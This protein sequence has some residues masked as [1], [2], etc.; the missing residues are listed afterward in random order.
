MRAHRH[1]SAASTGIIPNG[2]AA[3]ALEA[4]QTALSGARGMRTG[5]LRRVPSA[6]R[7]AFSARGR[8]LG[9]LRSSTGSGWSAAHD[10]GLAKQVIG[11]PAVVPTAGDRVSVSAEDLSAGS[12]SAW[13]LVAAMLP[14]A[15][16]SILADGAGCPGGSMVSGR[17]AGM[18][19]ASRT[20][21]GETGSAGWAGSAGACAGVGGVSAGLGDPPPAASPVWETGSSA[22]GGTAAGSED[23]VVTPEP[24]GSVPG[25]A[26]TPAESVGVAASASGVV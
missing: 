5:M 6:R 15:P 8:A 22:A 25:P 17:A 23:S 16:S 13:P 18:G 14:F 1:P 24:G 3:H 21:V 4:E 12:T 20:P 11:A 19:F 26:G 10:T 2:L 9:R 7:L